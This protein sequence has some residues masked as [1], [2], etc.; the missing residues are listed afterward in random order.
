MK[1]QELKDKILAMMISVNGDDKRTPRTK[2][3]T[4]K[5]GEND[6]YEIKLT[7]EAC[8]AEKQITITE[9]VSNLDNY[10]SNTGPVGYFYKE[11]I[12][13]TYNFK[14]MSCAVLIELKT[15]DDGVIYG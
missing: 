15:D 5:Y 14:T 1:T 9:Y 10:I 13:E 6:I 4:I 8:G 2:I 11:F 12:K 7:V 3:E